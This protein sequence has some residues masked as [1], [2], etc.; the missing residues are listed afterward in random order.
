VPVYA[1]SN[2]QHFSPF[3]LYA[4]GE[5]FSGIAPWRAIALWQAGRREIEQLGLLKTSQ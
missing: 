5:A 4:M 1:I 2:E 3:A